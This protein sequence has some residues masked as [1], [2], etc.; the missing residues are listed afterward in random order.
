MIELVSMLVKDR[1]RLLRIEEEHERV[2]VAMVNYHLTEEAYMAEG[3]TERYGN[4]QSASEAVT[5][6]AKKLAGK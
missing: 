3:S 6:L 4:Y 5:R 2:S 1:H